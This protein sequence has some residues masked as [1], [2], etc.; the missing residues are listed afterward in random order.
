VIAWALVCV[1]C[2]S[3][4]ELSSSRREPAVE[5]L[6]QAT[7]EIRERTPAE[8]EPPNE[9]QGVEPERVATSEAQGVEP[10]RV[11]PE[12]VPTEAHDVE[13]ESVPTET[14][15][16]EEARD[17]E[18]EGVPREHAAY[19]TRVSFDLRSMPHRGPYDVDEG[20]VTSRVELLMQRARDVAGEPAPRLSFTPGFS[21]FRADFE[22]ATA[23]AQCRRV[24][25]ALAT[26]RVEGS[27]PRASFGGVRAT[28][29]A[30]V[31]VETSAD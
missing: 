15:G 21:V 18:P 2:A 5:R 3:E 22:G 31:D 7:P 10:E 28:P 1:G 13:P 24:V 16:A 8:P 20:F 11:E 14:Q 27:T 26:P 4:P 12:R 6:A 9:A 30:P 19:F 29:C 23:R 25:A 17:V